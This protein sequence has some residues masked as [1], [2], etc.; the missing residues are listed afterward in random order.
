VA[1]R[2][3]RIG[4]R[5]DGRPQ[6]QG[7][8][9]S[10]RRSPI[11]S[12]EQE[13]GC[14]TI[15]GNRPHRGH[16]S[17]DSALRLGSEDYGRSGHVLVGC[18]SRDLVATAWQSIGDPVKLQLSAMLEIG[19]L[20]VAVANTPLDLPLQHFSVPENAKP[21]GTPLTFFG[22]RN[23]YSKTNAKNPPPKLPS[24]STPHINIILHSYVTDFCENIAYAK[25][26][27][28]KDGVTNILVDAG[29][30]APTF[31]EGPA[32]DTACN[33]LW[34]SP[35]GRYMSRAIV[36]TNLQNQFAA[37]ISA[38]DPAS[39][40]IPDSMSVACP[41]FD[42]YVVAESADPPAGELGR[43]EFYLDYLFDPT[44]PVLNVFGVPTTGLKRLRTP[45]VIA[46]G[47]SDLSKNPLREA[48]KQ[49]DQADRANPLATT[50]CHEMGHTFGLRHSVAFTDR[51]RTP[52]PMRRL[53][54]APCATPVFI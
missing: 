34:Q 28:V 17:T 10:G 24:G 21:T 37:A 53:S 51:R 47:L 1:K 25:M 16:E 42:F 27:D 4:N 6:R 26:Q 52:P 44:A 30:S 31:L 18:G 5:A 35:Q 22:I 32:A 3:D 23:L 38:N 2:W 9:Q 43:S 13:E 54:A 12:G 36:N 7:G 11:F 49:I 40:T 48:L 39:V 8:L 29:F 50:I 41:F 15:Y 46:K 20:P 19:G 45:I 33:L 14:G